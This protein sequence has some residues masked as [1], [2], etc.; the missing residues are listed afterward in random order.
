MDKEYKSISDEVRMW[1]ESSRL[2]TKTKMQMWNLLKEE[3][4][5]YAVRI[6]KNS[7]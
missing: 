5:R 6:Q 3:K 7:Y 2:S 4:K 1:M